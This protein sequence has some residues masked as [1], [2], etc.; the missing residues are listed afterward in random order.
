LIKLAKFPV[1]NR[2][3]YVTLVCNSDRYSKAS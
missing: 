1:V 3:A 2:A